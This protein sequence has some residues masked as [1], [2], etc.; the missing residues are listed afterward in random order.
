MFGHTRTEFVQQF[1]SR[2]ITTIVICPSIL[3]EL[4]IESVLGLG[5]SIMPS[6]I[7]WLDCMSV[8][9]VLQRGNYR[10]K[11]VLRLERC[12][13]GY[14]AYIEARE[15]R[16]ATK[17]GMQVLLSIPSQNS[18]FWV[19]LPFA[20]STVQQDVIRRLSRDQCSDTRE[21]N[22]CSSSPHTHAGTSPTCVRDYAG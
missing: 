9:M 12:L 22:S 15:Q 4:G 1:A 20:D 19:L 11:V 10:C 17:F 7:V 5:M 14:V 21:Q 16:R 8:H 18:K 2:Y 3:C 6:V 13:H